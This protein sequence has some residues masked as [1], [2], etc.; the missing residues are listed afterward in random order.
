M[1]M[2]NSHIMTRVSSLLAFWSVVGF[3][4]QRKIIV[5]WNSI[6]PFW[7]IAFCVDMKVHLNN[8]QCPRYSSPYLLLV[9]RIWWQSFVLALALICGT[10][11]RSLFLACSLAS[12]TSTKRTRERSCSRHCPSKPAHRLQRIQWDFGVYLRADNQINFKSRN[13]KQTKQEIPSFPHGKCL[14][15]LQWR[16]GRT[17]QANC[18]APIALS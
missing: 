3:E 17:R 12:T 1:D 10:L 16:L 7:E 13:G 8:D 5:S 18:V 4:E 15:V 9:A 2:Q 11:L 14:G 6:S